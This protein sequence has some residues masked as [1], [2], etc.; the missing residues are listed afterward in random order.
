MWSAI[1]AVVGVVASVVAVVGLLPL[2]RRREAGLRA[3]RATVIKPGPK[4]QDEV[5]SDAIPNVP[6]D[7]VAAC[8]AGECVVSLAAALAS[9]SASRPGHSC[10][11]S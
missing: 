7:L 4:W 3:D 6:S 9:S 11:A 5:A 10:S 8:A 2:L 1:G